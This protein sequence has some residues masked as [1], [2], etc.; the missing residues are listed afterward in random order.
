M[1]YVA[2]EGHRVALVTGAVPSADGI[3]GTYLH[4]MAM[5]ECGRHP[6]VQ[7]SDGECKHWAEQH[8]RE[9]EQAREAARERRAQSWL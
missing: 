6:D 1:I 4:T 5:C 2:T 8:V 9:V 7:G 3:S